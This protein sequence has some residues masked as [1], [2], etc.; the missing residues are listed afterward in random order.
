MSVLLDEPVPDVRAR[1]EQRLEGRAPRLVKLGVEYPAD[2]RALAD[3][4]A[5]QVLQDLSPEQVFRSLYATRH[6]G[7]LPDALLAAFHE[8]VDE[9]KQGGAR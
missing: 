4:A 8:L 9:V 1:V 3:V 5:Q 2:R 7:E 6:D